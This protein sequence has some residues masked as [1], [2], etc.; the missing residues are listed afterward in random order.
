MSAGYAGTPK[1]ASSST[2]GGNMPQIVAHGRNADGLYKKRGIWYFR[3]KDVTGKLRALST[4]TRNYAE[5]KSIK[6]AKEKEIQGGISV[7]LSRRR[8]CDFAQEWLEH[9]RIDLSPRTFRSYRWA[10]NLSCAAFGTLT[11]GNITLEI[12]RNYQTEQSKRLAP[13]SINV[14]SQVIVS[15]MQ[16][17][18]LGQRI[19]GKLKRLR[20]KEERGRIFKAEELQRI[21]TT[22][23]RRK[24]HIKYAIRLFLE[25]G[26]RHKEL[27]TIRLGNIN[28]KQKMLSIPRDSTKSDSGVRVIPLTDEACAALQQLIT[29]AYKLGASTD[30]HYLLPLRRL[31]RGVMRHDPTAPQ[32]PLNDAWHDLKKAAGVDPRLRIHDL[33]HH[34]VTEMAAAGVPG[35]VAMK[36]LGWSSM[37]MFGRYEHLQSDALRAGI[38]RWSS[39]RKRPVSTYEATAPR[40]S[41]R[42][43]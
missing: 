16:D 30:A 11:L 3:V 34:V 18:E 1:A 9:K 21:L 10:V 27:R 24:S 5:A 17:A 37:N 12:L 22:A 26:M 42:V 6:A 35:R 33:R 8:Y 20:V 32:E 7:D 28:L 36:L 19:K 13:G 4:R 43:A 25:T 23:D 2:Q 31:E 29:R 14:L 40:S 15:I 39:A 38:D 41:S